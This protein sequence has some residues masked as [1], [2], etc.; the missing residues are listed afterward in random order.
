MKKK[1]NIINYFIII[2][3]LILTTSVL[4]YIFRTRVKIVYNIFST[5]ISKKTEQDIF[6]LYSKK[7]KNS[8]AKSFKSSEIVYPP[9]KIVLIAIKDESILELWAT[10]ET[11]TK[12]IKKY[13]ILAKSG[14]LGPKLK[15]GDRQI[16]EGVYDIEY[17]NPNSRYHLSLRV[18]Y[19]NQFDLDMAQKDG[20]VNLGGDIMIHGSNVSIG[21]IAIGDD[22]IEEVFTIASIV[23]KENI[24]VIISPTDFRKK[25]LKNCNLLKNIHIDWIEALY[26]K[27]EQELLK[28]S[29]L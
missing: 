6:N 20:R 19:P 22:N 16:P 28:F 7:V 15:S 21:C 25:S 18:N 12:L 14:K 9:K 24:R 10:D 1:R 8:L 26:Q 17:L 5:K 2:T 29:D 11:K 4:L 13:P 23:K 3:I 27:I